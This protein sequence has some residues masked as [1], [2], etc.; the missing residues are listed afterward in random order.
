MLDLE[1]DLEADAKTTISFA[2]ATTATS[3]PCKTHPL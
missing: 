3:N 1:K 2:P